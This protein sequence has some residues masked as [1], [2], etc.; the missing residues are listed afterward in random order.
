MHAR[1][2]GAGDRPDARCLAASAG[3][4]LANDR[5]NADNA[6]PLMPDVRIRAPWIA[7]A[8]AIGTL[9]LAAGCGGE[10]KPDPARGKEL[11]TQRCGACHILEN[12]GTKGV[13]GPNLDLAFKQS[14][15]DGLGRSTI[16]GVVRKQIALPQGGQ[17][18]AD[19]VEGKD[20]DAVA[21]Y[22]ASAIGKKGSGGGGGPAG[23]AKADAQNTVQIP[24]DANGQLA[25][26]FKSAEAKAGQGHDRV[27]ERLVGP[28]QHR[29]RGRARGRDR[30][31]RQDLHDHGEPEARQADLLLQRSRPRAGRDEGHADRQVAPHMVRRS[32]YTA[33]PSR[34]R[35][36]TTWVTGR[37]KRSWARCTTSCSSQFE[38]PA[39]CVEMITSS[40][41]NRRSASSMA[42]TGSS[43]PMSPSAS[44]PSP[45]KLRQQL[46]EALLSSSRAP[47]PP[48]W[49]SA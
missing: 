43:S 33:L 13:Q 7:A 34:S 44:K 35:S 40:A 32:L 26:Q 30:P 15:A 8:L 42:W 5:A 39:G 2:F 49:S 41:G 22:V 12:A 25:Y 31:G 37:S 46:L 20:A 24:T 38:R 4:E 17:M 10:R 14:V 36:T 28:A 29:A 6:R 3:C 9:F 48:R 1:S 19:L 23:T 45:R 11:F 21:A 18:P 16:E 47:R 27:A